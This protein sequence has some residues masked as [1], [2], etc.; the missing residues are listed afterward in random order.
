MKTVLLTL[1]MFISSSLAF[2]AEIA[3]GSDGGMNRC[4]LPGA[5]KKG[6]K[7][8]QVLEGKCTFDKSWWTDSDG[9]VVDKGCNAVFSYKTGSSKSS[10]AS[11]PSNMD[12]ANC[13]YYRDGYKAGAQDR[14]AHLSQ[15]YERHEGKYDSQFEKAFSSGYM[16]GWNK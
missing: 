7:I 2:S 11:C 10:G 15:A 12:Q 1:A 16:A 9:I 13:D 5:D 8:Q 4:P 3:C 14:K 6:V